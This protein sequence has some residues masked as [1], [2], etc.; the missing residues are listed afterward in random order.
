MSDPATPERVVTRAGIVDLVAAIEAAM[1]RARE[2]VDALNVFPVPDGDTGTNLVMT[3]RSALAEVDADAEPATRARQLGHGAVR[4]ARGNSGVI[5]SQVLRGLLEHVGDDPFDTEDLASF[6]R[7]A[8]DLSYDAVADPV[9]GTILSAL[10]EAA[11]AAERAV[12]DRLD[13]AAAMEVVTDAMALAVARTRNVL[14]ANRLAGV[15]DAGARGLE[16]AL[17]AVR[18]HLAGDEVPDLPPPVRRADSAGPIPRESGSLDYDYEVQYLL[19]ADD[20]RA[21][22]LREALSGLGDS[23]VVVACGGLL[24][25]HVHT[26]EV[27]DAVAAGRAH[28]TPRRVEVHAFADQIDQPTVEPTTARRAVGHVAVL[29]SAQLAA[30]VGHDGIRVIRGGP[31]DLPTVADLLRAAG[32]V[33]AADVVV[34]PGH[35]NAVPTAVQAARVSRAEDGPD[36][37][38]VTRATSVPAV[39]AAMAV[40]DDEVVDLEL[41]DAAAADVVVAEVVAAVRSATTSV[42][43]VDEGEWL[44][45]VRGDIV[46]ASHDIAR[47]RT[48]VLDHLLADGAELVTLLA[49][50]S[51]TARERDDWVAAV[52]DRLPDAEVELV[53]AALPTS[54]WL[55]GAEGVPVRH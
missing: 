6:L 45:L 22:P 28:G 49:G 47:V 42:G 14:E 54:R 26:N 30:L 21:A 23:V 1:S 7:A 3:L 40:S 48:L 52:R 20:E 4:G 9:D 29:P 53:E 39:L 10:D 16:V 51:T 46:A 41:L 19:E 25:V 11:A 38:V 33:N 15:V 12:A 13:L 50:A 34:L 37:H 43:D 36:L 44:V 5:F 18:A 35:R 27:D 17:V 32:E 2:E 55:V 24:N 8:T 31:G